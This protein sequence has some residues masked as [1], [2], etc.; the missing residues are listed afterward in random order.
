M[1]ILH[2][3]AAIGLLAPRWNRFV[4]AVISAFARTA[5]RHPATVLSFA[6]PLIGV[7]L[8]VFWALGLGYPID[9]IEGRR[10]TPPT[11]T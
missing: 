10:S 2:A 8:I 7:S 4:W 5:G 11:L 3:R 6:G 9:E 1:T